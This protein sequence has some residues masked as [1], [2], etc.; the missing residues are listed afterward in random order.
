[1]AFTFFSLVFFFVSNV[2][3]CIHEKGKEGSVVF[4]SFFFPPQVT[5]RSCTKYIYIYNNTCKNDWEGVWLEERKKDMFSCPIIYYYN[6][7]IKGKKKRKKKLYF[8]I[9]T[10]ELGGGGFPIFFSFHF[11]FLYLCKL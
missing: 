11:S 5:L 7:K 6:Y 4:F 2:H 8:P 9:Y 1:M 3:I 10:L